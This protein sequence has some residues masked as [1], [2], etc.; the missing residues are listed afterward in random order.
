MIVGLGK[1]L[2]KH[3]SRDTQF[4]SSIAE[5]ATRDSRWQ[6]RCGRY[7]GPTAEY[8]GQC[9]SFWQ[10]GWYGYGRQQRP[11]SR[12]PSQSRRSQ[13]GKGKGKDKN[14]GKED[15][16][17][18]KNSDAMTT[19]RTVKTSELASPDF[20]KPSTTEAK[21]NVDEKE[22]TVYTPEK[23]SEGAAPMPTHAE[24]PAQVLMSL[25]KDVAEGKASAEEALQQATK[26][27]GSAS[28]QGAADSRDV[29]KCGRQLA[30]AQAKTKKAYETLKKMKE[31]WSSWTKQVQELYNRKVKQY[32]EAHRAWTLVLQDALTAE[33]AAKNSLKEL[34]QTLPNLTLE[35]IELDEKDFPE[36]FDVADTAMDG[37]STE[38][39]ETSPVHKPESPPVRTPEI[40]VNTPEVA[41][42]SR[43]DDAARASKEKEERE[44]AKEKEKEKKRRKGAS[45]VSE[46][47]ANPTKTKKAALKDSKDTTR[48]RMLQ[49]PPKENRFAPLGDEEKIEDEF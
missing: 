10:S 15:Q 4:L 38:L 14:G 22:K 30:K 44:R 24:V 39:R 37:E 48:Q 26:A 46:S 13:K 1:L 33:K 16:Q 41:L 12:A 2:A 9:G 17:Q 42:S 3:H 5:M 8:C 47:S 28:N 40:P 32:E 7:N 36:V 18:P 19:P 43:L 25:L 6:C 11:K 29:H 34:G 31:D 23:A 27:T 49:F 21:E 20:R 35:E 45:N